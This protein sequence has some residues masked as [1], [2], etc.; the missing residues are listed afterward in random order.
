MANII[1]NGIETVGTYDLYYTTE[2]NGE[3]SITFW[4][5]DLAGNEEKHHSIPSYR[6]DL[7]PPI[8]T[9]IGPDPGFYLFG[10]KKLNLNKFTIIFGAFAIEANATDAES[11]IYKV[12]FY[13]DGDLI[14]EDTEAPYSAYCA[15][16]HR[17]EGV[18]KVVA[19]DFS[20]NTDEKTLDV[21]YYKFL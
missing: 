12:A 9:S 19:E 2:V 15:I 5:V 13:I 3:H 17:G 4:S 6:V 10:N 20:M 11:G 16:R 14:G 8:I 18:I 1:H 21:H 7:K